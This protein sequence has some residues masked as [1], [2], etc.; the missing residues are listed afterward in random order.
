[1]GFSSWLAGFVK[2]LRYGLRQIR[3]TPGFASV[4]VL[5]LAL[6]IGANTAVFSVMN[7]VILRYLPVPNPQ[8]LVL[9]HYVNQP[10]SS[11]QTGYGDESLPEPAFEQLRTQ[12]GVFSDLMAFAP[13]GWGKIPVRIGSDPEEASADEVSGNF[14]SGLGVEITRGRAFNLDDEKNHTQ[15][16]ILGHAYWSW[17]FASDP[18]ILG[19]T[20]YIKGVAF[21][22]VGVA[23]P[24]FEGLEHGQTTDVWVPLQENPQLKPWGAPG[25]EE[26][27]SLYGTPKWFFLM[28]I[29][30]L[31][32]GVSPDRALA[33][34]NPVYRQAV[35]DT[36]GQPKADEK[37]TELKLTAVRGVEGLNRAYKE[38]SAVLMA[39]VGLVLLIACSNVATLLVARNSNRQREFSVRIALGATRGVMFR[40]LLMESLLLVTAGGVLGWLFALL[41]TRTLAAWARLEVSLAPDRL[42][43]LFAVAICGLAALVFGLAPLRSAT[44][45]P[46]GMA[47]KTAA[48]ASNQDRRKIGSGHIVVGLQVALCLMLLVGGGLLVRTLL[49]LENANLGLQTKGLVVFGVTPPQAVKNDAEAVQF[50]RTILGRLRALPEVESATVMQSRLGAGV[51]SNTGVYVDGVVPNGKRIAMIRW[52]AVGPDFLHVLRIPILQGRD[53]TDADSATSPRVA[54]INQL[55]AKTYM[56]DVNPV[57]HR[58]AL[59]GELD[60]PNYTIVGV[61]SDS[62]YTRVRE[63]PIP[64]VY[65]PFTQVEGIGTIQ[66]E[67]R[68]GNAVAAL[69]DARRVVKEFGLDLPLLH[70]MTQ[71]EQFENSFSDEHMFARLAV[72]F[73]VLAAILVA[74]GLYGTMAYRVN[75]RTAEIGVRM[76]LGAQRGQVLWMVLRESLLVCAFGVAIGFPAA[77]ACSRLLRSMLF[78]LPPG[79]PLTFVLALLAISLVTLLAA[80]MPARRASSVDP[81]VALRY[82]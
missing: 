34:L 69:N 15:V 55:F 13:L 16:A 21:T 3:R 14:F 50:F 12:T 56:K 29:G 10:E 7:A 17:R 58:L 38:P 25:A 24:E 26:D 63:E 68:T 66:I 45:V 5:T 59:Y 67:L 36:I 4:A 76:A 6:G 41:A 46:A 19:R 11:S 40:Q 42:V 47:L 82:E 44:K 51:S 43:L 52:N 18:A 32:P 27:S 39:M 81:I 61:V 64:M 31:Q 8:Q 74:T 2:D 53:I 72:F 73:G 75:R 78:D 79:D 71:Q 37:I 70:P 33:Q 62:K 80:A 48:S 54:I 77:I 22:I 20:I 28:M 35:Y 60:K 65:L 23:P 1:M 57:G 49:N 30:R 9:L